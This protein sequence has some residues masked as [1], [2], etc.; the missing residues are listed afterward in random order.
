[1]DYLLAAYRAGPDREHPLRTIHSMW[2]I[3]K[4][5]GN[6]DTLA[7]TTKMYC[8]AMKALIRA[9][10]ASYNIHPDS[11][12][13]YPGDIQAI[14]FNDDHRENFPPSVVEMSQGFTLVEDL[15]HFTVSVDAATKF[16][17]FKDDPTISDVFGQVE[18]DDTTAVFSR[19]KTL[20]KAMHHPY[21][22]MKDT[23]RMLV[24]Y[25]VQVQSGA[26]TSDLVHSNILFL[27]FSVTPDWFF[28][29]TM[30]RLN[31]TFSWV[32]EIRK[33]FPGRLP[34]KIPSKDG[35]FNMMMIWVMGVEEILPKTR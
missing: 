18:H 13:V 29:K 14:V 27:T 12:I 3:S 32:L 1:M 11:P 26:I 17:L 16:G 5:A 19:V 8:L 10:E 15:C 34:W 22:W 25:V 9:K 23:N 6:I 7:Y 24:E 4:N 21:I 2:N 20:E 31:V 33:S 35:P 30:I 28:F